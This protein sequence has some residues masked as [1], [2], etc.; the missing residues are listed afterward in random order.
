MYARVSTFEG[1][2]GTTEEQIQEGTRLIREQI[3][4]AA[5][6]LEGFMGIISLADR[7]SG[8]ELTVT[9]WESEEALRASEEAANRLR[10]EAAY[11]LQA[12]I[13]LVERYEVIVSEVKTPALTG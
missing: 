4:P 7:Q 11:A 3:L 6:Q 13:Q 5:Q 10:K 1:P 12:R 8:K 2:A 9:L